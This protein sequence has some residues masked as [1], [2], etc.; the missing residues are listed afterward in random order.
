MPATKLSHYINIVRVLHK[1]GSKTFNQLKSLFESCDKSS[2][3]CDL[4]FLAVN[5]IISKQSTEDM[6]LC[7]AITPIG[8]NILRFFR[9]IPSPEA[10]ETIF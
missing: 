8:L 3:E 9:V 6:C 10:I 7:F 1:D 2:L 5:K 4:D